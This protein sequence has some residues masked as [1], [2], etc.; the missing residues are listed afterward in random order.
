MIEFT[1]L[2]IKEIDNH[3]VTKKIESSYPEPEGE[4]QTFTE[5]CYDVTIE[6]WTNQGGQKVSPN[7][8]HRFSTIWASSREELDNKIYGLMEGFKKKWQ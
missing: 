8:K 1:I 5:Y 6:Y 3:Q 2:D 7:G 4:L